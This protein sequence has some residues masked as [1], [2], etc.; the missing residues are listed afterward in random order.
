MLL[1]H[2]LGASSPLV[3]RPSTQY[4]YLPIMTTTQQ[5]KSLF[6]SDLIRTR[7]IWV[8]IAANVVLAIGKALAGIFGHSTA[9][10]ADAMESFSDAVWSLVTLFA[11]RL[12][13]R[14]PD[15]AHPYG[16]GKVEPLFTLF[17]S[18]LLIGSTTWL[19]VHIWRGMLRPAVTTPSWFTIWILVVILGIKA[20]QF[21]YVR[22]AARHVKSIVLDAEAQHHQIDALTSFAAL[23]GLL[24]VRYGPPSAAKADHVAA[25]LAISIVFFT[26]GKLFWAAFQELMD[27]HPQNPELEKALEMLPSQLA[28][29]AVVEK[30]RIRK[31]GIRYYIDLHLHISGELSVRE[32]HEIAHQAKDFLRETCPTIAD[33]LVHVEPAN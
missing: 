3:S 32:G 25:L 31:M 24:L 16:H 30:Y 29:P 26:L 20:V 23:L 5:R 7:T 9:L 18:L 19:G 17:A 1:V 11:I 28:I 14:P 8:M 33:V 6:V 13:N 10:L 15:S 12:S 2:F 22:R 4:R 21:W 27:E